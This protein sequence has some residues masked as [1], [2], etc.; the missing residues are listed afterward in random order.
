MNT[1]KLHGI[2][3][4][5]IAGLILIIFLLYFSFMKAKDQANQKDSVI[6]ELNSELTLRTNFEG[7]VIAEKN[8]AVVDLDNLKKSYPKLVDD[9]NQKLE[10]KTRNIL[11]AIDA[12]FTAQGSGR[13]HVIHDTVKT[14]SGAQEPRFHVDIDDG[15]LKL[16][17]DTKIDV[18]DYVD[19]KYQYS[20]TLLL[21]ISEKNHFFKGKTFTVSGVLSN[22]NAHLTEG[23]GVLIHK[24]KAK[25][26]N[27]SIGAYYDPITQ[28]FGPA[29]TAGYSLIRF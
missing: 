18:I 12:K 19:Y 5:G 1:K 29:I 24:E 22:K 17:G 26:F 14:E 15:Y 10:I 27:V 21:A 16:S 13:V 6:K 23:T 7:R 3:L 9:I 11:A 28:R 4:C 20:D 8:A 25:R 2:Y